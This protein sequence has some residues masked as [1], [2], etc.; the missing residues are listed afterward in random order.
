MCRNC[1]ALYHENLLDAGV[2]LRPEPD[3][4][5]R[6]AAMLEADAVYHELQADAKRRQASLLRGKKQ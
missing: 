3:P 4:I 1:H 2:D 6:V 5:N